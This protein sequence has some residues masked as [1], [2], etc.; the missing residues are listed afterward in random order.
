MP[1][2]VLFRVLFHVRNA[3]KLHRL[4]NRPDWVMFVQG[5]IAMK[6]RSLDAAE[7]AFFRQKVEAQYR[8]EGG[9]ELEWKSYLPR[10]EDL[11]EHFKTRI[12]GH[13]DAAISPNIL[14]RLFWESQGRTGSTFNIVYLNAFARFISDGAM[15]YR[16]MAAS[17]IAAQKKAEPV[18]NGAVPHAPDIDLGPAVQGSALAPSER[19]ALE[20]DA[21]RRSPAPP[22]EQDENPERGRSTFPG[23]PG[24]ATE[25]SH[26]SLVKRSMTLTSQALLRPF[27]IAS[28]YSGLLSFVFVL[29]FNEISGYETMGRTG[30][31][32]L[33]ISWFGFTVFGHFA[34]GIVLSFFTQRLTR[35]VDER[36]FF[37]T[38]YLTLP[39]LFMLTFYCRQLFVSTGWLVNG[40]AAV[41]FFGRPD[42]ET[43]AIALSLCLFIA[44]FL[45]SIRHG[46]SRNEH[47][48]ALQ[49]TLIT[50]SCGM[51][52]F[53]I[54]AAYNILVSEHVIDPTGY[55]IAP[56][57]FSYRFPHPERLPLI[58]FMIFI[59]T[60]LTLKSL[61]ERFE[62]RTTSH[63]HNTPIDPHQ[64]STIAQ[65]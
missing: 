10:Y 49:A 65:P 21:A 1:F 58:C 27:L 16:E 3:L 8:A 28:L 6:L 2:R 18:R 48:P 43:I 38:F 29:L 64:G 56:Y 42:F 7:L 37:R 45:R 15:G 35:C 52:F 5:P 25:G 53:A 50:L 44:L 40:R 61:E 13:T 60:F 17:R 30:L 33:M 22:T 20:K 46:K 14:R 36:R 62:Q 39:F 31:S 55:F 9:T 11:H 23:T 26:T 41:G 51:I 4:W 34:L 24:V 47:T 32:K 59:Q 63:V 12:H 54:A 57:I 19:R